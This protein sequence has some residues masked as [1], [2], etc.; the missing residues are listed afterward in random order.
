MTE[1]TPGDVL[2][3]ILNMCE[4]EPEAAFELL[5]NMVANDPEME[6][7]AFLLFARAMAFAS[8]GLYTSLR[9]LPSFNLLTADA[10]DMRFELGIQEAQV[11][12]LEKALACIRKLEAHH[13]GALAGF[14]HDDGD[15][16]GERKVDGAAIVVDAFKPGRV[17][18]ILGKTKLRYFGASRIMVHHDCV[19]SSDDFEI[20]ADSWIT[21]DEVARSV[22]LFDKGVDRLERRYIHAMFF[23][24]LESEGDPEA[25]IGESLGLIGSLYLFEDGTAAAQRPEDVEFQK[26]QEEIN[27]ESGERTKDRKRFGRRRR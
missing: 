7:D 21:L 6:F 23:R 27:T 19:S 10:N 14:E 26:L 18:E 9:R 4:A 3:G 13:P 25:P 24:R 2:A 8:R 20:A 11:A 1:P 17:Q 15:R 12:D 22:L 16:F 5:D